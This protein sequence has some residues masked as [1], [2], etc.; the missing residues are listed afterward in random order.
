MQ[1][2]MATFC[3]YLGGCWAGWWWW[4]WRG[5]VPLI[6]LELPAQCRTAPTPSA[7]ASDAAHLIPSV[8]Q[9]YPAFLKDQTRPGRRTNFKPSHVHVHSHAHARVDASV[10][11]RDRP[12]HS[13]QPSPWL[14]SPRA[15]QNTSYTPTP[16]S[17]LSCLT[18][19][20]LAWGIHR[21][22]GSVGQSG[23]MRS[24]DHCTIALL[25][26]SYLHNIMAKRRVICEPFSILMLAPHFFRLHLPS[27]AHRLLTASRTKAGLRK[28]R[29]GVTGL[30]PPA[31]SL[32]LRKSH[33]NAARPDKGETSRQSLV[34]Q[35]PGFK[36]ATGASCAS[37]ARWRPQHESSTVLLRSIWTISTRLD[38][39]E[40]L[41]GVSPSNVPVQRPEISQD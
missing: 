20:R 13:L 36:T 41:L 31:A 30:T 9:R 2:A 15:H 4:C 12:R 6:A 8:T 18:S 34:F 1:L 27:L 5:G 29:S 22:H 14:Y 28:S 3:C 40:K 7:Q 24:C 11:A 26:R 35:G 23:E 39:S 38:R 21:L 19:H 33:P 17:C 37:P 16:H 32:L 10:L 25:R